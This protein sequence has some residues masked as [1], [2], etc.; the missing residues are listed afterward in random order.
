MQPSNNYNNNQRLTPRVSLNLPI[1]ISYGSQ[2]SVRGMLKDLSLKSAFIIIKNSIY[3]QL[4]DE[5]NFSILR[6]SSSDEA[7]VQGTACISRIVGGEGI[8]IYFTKLDETSEARLKELVA[9]R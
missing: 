5:I 8:A 7:V 2:I 3:M 4:N 9:A 6:S 1:Q